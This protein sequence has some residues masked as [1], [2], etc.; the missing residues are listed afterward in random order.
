VNK[1]Y[2]SNANLIFRVDNIQPILLIKEMSASRAFYR[3]ILGFTEAEWGTNNFSF[4]SR[5]KSGIYLCREGQG[6]PGT[7]VW[8]GIEG[9][10]EVLYNSLKGKGVKIRQPPVRYS[11]AVEMHIEDPDGNVLRLGADP[12]VKI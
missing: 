7:W 9:D 1:K 10:I 8:I 11:Y 4:F 5:D 3:D 2:P 12:N 6:N